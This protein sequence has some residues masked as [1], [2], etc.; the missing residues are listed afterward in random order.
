MAPEALRTDTIKRRAE[1]R[2]EG[3]PI[4]SVYLDVETESL[5]ARGSR[6]E[7]RAASAQ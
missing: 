2:T 1:F 3:R 4:L 5:S 7:P 6:L